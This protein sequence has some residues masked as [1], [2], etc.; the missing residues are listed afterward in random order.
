MNFTDGN[1]ENETLKNRIVYS[2]PVRLGNWNED[3]ALLEE[4]HRITFQKQSRCEL[5]VQKLKNVY[6]NLLRG[7]TLAKQGAYIM[8]GNN[9]QLQACEI[10]NSMKAESGCNTSY[11]LY[12][13]GLISEYDIDE[14][15][16]FMHGCRLTASPN[17]APLVRNTFVFVSCD[18]DS[19]NNEPVFYG[20]DLYIRIFEAGDLPLYVQC[21]CASIDTFGGHLTL[22]L[23][24]VPDI[25]CRFK[26]LHCQSSLRYETRD[27]AIPQD[28]RVIIQHTASG[29][30]LAVEPSKWLAT[31]FGAEC[32]VSCHTFKNS[33]RKETA[34]NMWK[35]IAAK[36][37][38]MN[39]FVRAAKG[40][41]IPADL[42][43]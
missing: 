12:L 15:Q 41:D 2:L 40:E 34:E 26:I 35:V 8:Y 28:S 27:T 11:G 25:Y 30:N 39:L 6:K 23:S 38:N 16:H 17:K 31:F 21:E 14:G 5:T 33:H 13:S 29:Q 4:K 18:S 42:L 22:R 10:P 20:Q 24:Q 3:L 43:E 37:P 32:L 1:E 7:T 9:Y 36:T 19:K